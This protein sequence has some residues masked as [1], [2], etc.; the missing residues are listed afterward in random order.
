MLAIAGGLLLAWLV[1]ELIKVL[2]ALMIHAQPAVTT[3]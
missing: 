3:P 2:A 1:I